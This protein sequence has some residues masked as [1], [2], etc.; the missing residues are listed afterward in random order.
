MKLSYFEKKFGK[1]ALPAILCIDEREKWKRE[2][3]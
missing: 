3:Q 1:I 2:L